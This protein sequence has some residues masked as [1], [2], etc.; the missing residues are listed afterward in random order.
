[1]THE[2]PSHA[3]SATPSVVT[4]HT[5]GGH[6]RWTYQTLHDEQ[7]AGHGSGWLLLSS[8]PSKVRQELLGLCVDPENTFPAVVNGKPCVVIEQEF[9]ASD[10][11]DDWSET[12]SEV[13]ARLRR[14]LLPRLAPLLKDAESHVGI[15]A[16]R[17]VTFCG[18]PT[19]FVA[20]PVES[21]TPEHVSNVL[22][23]VR[24]FAYPQSH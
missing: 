3:Q 6:N 5:L 12:T 18:R 21:T 2:H 22:N 16:D 10:A 14:A 13:V 17:A 9:Q 1:M 4:A 19:L 11:G 20:L 23:S 8:L 15:V 24:G 7:P